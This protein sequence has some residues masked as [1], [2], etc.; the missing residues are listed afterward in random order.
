MTDNVLEYHIHKK[1]HINQLRGGSIKVV[2]IIAVLIIFFKFC[3]SEKFLLVNLNDLFCRMITSESSTFPCVLRVWWRNG[4]L[5]SR[6][7]LK[8]STDTPRTSASPATSAHGFRTSKCHLI[9]FSRNC[10]KMQSVPPLKLIRGPGERVF[11]PSMSPL[12]PTR[13]TSSSSKH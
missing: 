2:C 1:N 10:W 9:T 4:Q 3:N 11:R 12:P 8:T 13:G 7:W 6:T 5:L